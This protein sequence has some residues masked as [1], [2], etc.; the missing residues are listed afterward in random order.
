MIS[1]KLIHKTLFDNFWRVGESKHGCLSNKWSTIEINAD[2]AN[3]LK[4]RHSASK[5]LLTTPNCSISSNTSTACLQAYLLD[6]TTKTMHWA[7]FKTNKF[8]KVWE[9]HQNLIGKFILS[10]YWMT[11]IHFLPIFILLCIWVHPVAKKAEQFP[12]IVL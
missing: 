9:K 7:F 5:T 10:F 2:T 3:Y 1:L 11:C 6:R 4:P 12:L 8:Q